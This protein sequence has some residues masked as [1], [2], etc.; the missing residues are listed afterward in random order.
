VDTDIRDYPPDD[1]RVSDADRDGALRELSEAFQAGRITAG[2]FDQRSGQ[3]LGA[4]TGKELTALLADLPRDRARADTAAPR[5][6]H[7][8]LA[9]RIVI[10]ASAAAAASL[11][12]VAVTTGLSHP[13]PVRQNRQ[14]AQA[15]LAHMGLKVSL[16]PA[17]P[18]PGFDWGGTITPAAIAVLL[19]V[20]IV[21]VRRV[22]RTSRGEPRTRAR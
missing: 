2:E 4:R 17:P 18:P 1:L 15:I 7:R 12:A 14:L 5:Q 10:G 11:A 13:G 19:V 9:A 22:T 6:C 16:P 20:V 8:Q 21:A 3:A